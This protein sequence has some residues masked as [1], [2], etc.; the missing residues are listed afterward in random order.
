MNRRNMPSAPNYT[1]AAL[2]MGLVNLVWVFMVIWAKLGLLAV[3]ATGYVLNKLINRVA[4]A[5]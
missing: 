5:R 1:N 3:L 4:R 2:V